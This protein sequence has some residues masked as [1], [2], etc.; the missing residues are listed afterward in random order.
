M[1]AIGNDIARLRLC[2]T[3]DSNAHTGLCAGGVRQGDAELRVYVLHKAG[4]I[5]TRG[6][7]AAIHIG[8]AAELGSKAGHIS[9]GTSGAA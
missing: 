1:S 2:E 7:V 5:P 3:T 4:A 8:I 6:S 9:T